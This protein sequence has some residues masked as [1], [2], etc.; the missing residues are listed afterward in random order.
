MRLAN[1]ICMVIGG[2]LHQKNLLGSALSKKIYFPHFR[3][4]VLPDREMIYRRERFSDEAC[5]RF[6]E[7]FDVFIQKLK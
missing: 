1:E 2:R 7:I 3:V 6:F 5:F 4:D